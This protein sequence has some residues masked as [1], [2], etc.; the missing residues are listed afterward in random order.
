W[1]ERPEGGG[2]FGLWLIFTIARLCG[3]HVSRLLLY[4]IA[5]YFLLR[6]PRERHAARVFLSRLSG[7]RV[8]TWS[9]LAH[10]HRFA[11][12]LLDRVFFLARG[13]RGFAIDVA[14]LEVVESRL[15]KGRGLLLV[16]AHMGS[17]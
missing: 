6:R 3:R 2:R 9:L 15:A 10:F 17:F 4:P 14:G 16:G 11:A 5:A 8:G 13:V 12:T 1:H 7:Q